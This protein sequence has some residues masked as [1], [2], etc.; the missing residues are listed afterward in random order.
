MALLSSVILR[1]IA[2][3]RPTVGIAGRLF[4]DTTNGKWQR[5]TGA[6]WEDCEP[7]AGVGEYST[8]NFIIDGG[9]SAITTGVKGDLVIDFDCS[10]ISWTLLADASG[11][12]KID[13]WVEHYADYPPTDADSICNAHEPEIAASGVKAQDTDLSDWATNPPVI[14][15]GQTV[16]F[17]VDSAAAITR[18]TLALKVQRT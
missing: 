8:I 11:A 10:I 15:A 3:N 17:N 12:I 6:A 9:G 1:D 5:D 7:G 16:R 2:A 18:A 13:V 14:A 4:Y